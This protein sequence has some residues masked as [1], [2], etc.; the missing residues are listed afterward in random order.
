[1]NL[2]TFGV[3]AGTSSDEKGAPLSILSEHNY[4]FGRILSLGAITGIEQLNE[5]LMPVALN[6]KIFL[7]SGACELFVAGLGGYSI[8]LEKPSMEGIKKATGG[9]MAGAETGLL[10]RVN[11]ISS[12]V[13]ALGYRYNE[14]NYKL[15]DW[16][17]SDYERKISYN[18]FSLRIGIALY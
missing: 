14:L 12:I 11:G 17:L 15:Q 4:R 5:N 2:T 7:S 1:M 8:S 13:L 16:W 10:I 18:R 3:L 9:I 6:L